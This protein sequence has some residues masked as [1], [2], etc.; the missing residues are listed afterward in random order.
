MLRF[1]QT[2]MGIIDG[3]KQF[4]PCVLSKNM[5]SCDPVPCS[6]SVVRM[7]SI[8]CKISSRWVYRSSP[9]VASE[10]SLGSG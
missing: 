3:P 5:F 4:Q 8:F 2:V 10:W 6:A 9:F 7:F 1:E